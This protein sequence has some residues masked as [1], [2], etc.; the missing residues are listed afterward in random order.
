MK[1]HYFFFAISGTIG[2]ILGAVSSHYLKNLLFHGKITPETLDSFK[3]GVLYHL[4]HSL[5]LGILLNIKVKEQ[6]RYLNTSVALVELGMV[7]FSG[8]IYLLVLG[9]IMNSTMFLWLGPITPLGGIMLI[10]SWIMLFLH[11]YISYGSKIE[12]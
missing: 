6:S 4:V 11:F 10:A 7:C 12:K 5:F 2:V 3:T 8:S 1:R 9:K